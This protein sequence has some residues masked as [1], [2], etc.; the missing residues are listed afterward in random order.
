M[1]KNPAEAGGSTLKNATERRVFESTL[2]RARAN[3]GEGRRN[4]DRLAGAIDE[5]R[6][7]PDMAIRTSDG[8]LVGVEHFRVDGCVKPGRKAES[9][10]A[11]FAS[12]TEKIRQRAVSVA[13]GAP[14]VEEMAGIVVE[15]AN[16]WFR[17][18][19]N[20][21][22]ADLERSFEMRLVDEKLGHVPK[23]DAYRRNMEDCRERESAIEIAFL[24]EI[25]S[26][27]GGLFLNSGDRARILKCGEM[28]LYSQIYDMLLGISG[29]I[30]WLAMGFY[31]GN[32]S[33]IC[34]AAIIRCRNGL[35]RNSALMQGLRST[36]YLGLGRSEPKPTVSKAGV[37]C[38]QEEG[39]VTFSIGTSPNVD[40]QE[41]LLKNALID[42][43]TAL[44]LSRR[45]EPFTATL[46]VQLLFEL[47]R[48]HAKPHKGGL[49][50]DDVALLLSKIPRSE[51]D[52]GLERFEAEWGL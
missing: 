5:D 33:K 18:R 42:V 26:D 40:N 38:T 30:D 15:A 52:A 20:A 49:S 27:F 28:P 11:E 43:V 31:G 37:S 12:R 19:S 45:G 4:A 3:G 34:D 17:I 10:A 6:E 32:D 8:R 21:C 44:N 50:E 13:G 2:A 23:L 9:A 46:P 14:S 48:E 51:I 36:E 41:K 25:H 22:L 47:L 39:G 29:R 24:I 16:E 7:A 35:F 1:T